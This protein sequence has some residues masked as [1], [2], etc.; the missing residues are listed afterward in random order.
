MNLCGYIPESLNEGYG[1]R[2]VVFIS[3][4]RHACPG[5]F[6]PESWSFRAGEPFTPQ[7][8]QEVIRD[9]ME[10]PLLDGLTLCGG[11]PFFSAAEC[12]QF[13]RDFREACPDRTVWAYTGFVYEDLLT[14]QERQELTLLCDVI[15][16]GRFVEQQKD[17]TLPFRGS[18]NQRLVD[19]KASIQAG[20]TVSLT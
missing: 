5:C 14:D 16:D 15:V 17:L 13:V 12:S 1:L 3:G 11:D 7:R 6:N 8:Q 10:N 19:V 2:T 18:R 4:C 9:I 20:Y